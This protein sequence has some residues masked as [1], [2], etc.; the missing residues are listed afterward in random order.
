MKT[1]ALLQARQTVA[2][3]AGLCI[4]LVIIGVIAWLVFSFAVGLVIMLED[5]LL[6]PNGKGLVPGA[7]LFRKATGLDATG[8]GFALAASLLAYFALSVAVLIEARLRGRSRWRDVV[9]WFPW[10]PLRSDRRIYVIAAAA[11]AY[12]FLADF[13]L[14]YFHPQSGSWLTMPDNPAGAVALA[15]VA[16]V[17][18]P[19][20]E[21]LLF[22]GWIYTDLRRHFGFVTTLIVTSAIFAWLH[23]ESTHLYALAVFPI[24]LALGTMREITGSVKPSIVFHAF[25]NFLATAL[26]YLGF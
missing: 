16:V 11:L 3:L 17:S 20:A 9:A 13:A 4:G 15:I 1:E 22:R 8:V 10:N 6:G 21:E 14:H 26:A 12:G 19:L 2:A 25:N 24:G 5:V 7:R 18:A 23:Y